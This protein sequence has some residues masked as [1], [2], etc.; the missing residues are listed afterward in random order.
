[1]L[2]LTLING[3]DK[4]QDVLAFYK[5]GNDLHIL[6]AKFSKTGTGIDD[7]TF[8]FNF[9]VTTLVV[10]NINAFY[11]VDGGDVLTFYYNK[12]ST[13]AN[14]VNMKTYDKATFKSTDE[15]GIDLQFDKYPQISFRQAHCIARKGKHQCVFLTGGSLALYVVLEGGV[16]KQK[17]VLQWTSSQ[18]GFEAYVTSKHVIVQHAPNPGAEGDF[19]FFDLPAAS[20]VNQGKE[21]LYPTYRWKAPRGVKILTVSENN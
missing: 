4:S 8:E 19:T 2:R 6:P 7:W 18:P 12:K 20:S 21:I 16:V 17:E 10:E 9:E 1:V 15:T 3:K 5:S 13:M 11:F 14:F